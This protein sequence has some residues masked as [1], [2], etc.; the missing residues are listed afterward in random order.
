[1]RVLQLSLRC[2]QR[3]EQQHRDAQPYLS[4]ELMQPASR[5]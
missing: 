4:D 5:C 2:E 3:Y 1:M